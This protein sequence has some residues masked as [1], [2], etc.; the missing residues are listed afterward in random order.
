[1]GDFVPGGGRFGGGGATGSWGNPSPKPPPGDE[2]AFAVVDWGGITD[3]RFHQLAKKFRYLVEFNGKPIGHCVS[4]TGAKMSTQVIKYSTID[5]YR[6][7]HYQHKR[8]GGWNFTPLTLNR[9]VFIG[10]N[11]FFFAYVNHIMEN[12]IRGG[13]FDWQPPADKRIVIDVYPSGRTLPGSS[14]P[15]YGEGFRLHNAFISS[16]S[17]WDNYNST[18]S[19]ILYESVTFSFEYMESVEKAG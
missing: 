1:M 8:A 4:A 19:A 15:V 18:E 14:E 9:G 3:R 12:R 13:S 7:N 11:S 16:F 10:R 17:P 2:D 5:Y 6:E